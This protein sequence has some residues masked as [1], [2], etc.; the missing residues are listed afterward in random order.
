MSGSLLFD[1]MSHW[2]PRN[3]EVEWV[4]IRLNTKKGTSNVHDPTLDIQTVLNRNR[5]LQNPNIISNFS[6]KSIYAFHETTRPNQSNRNSA[7]FKLQIDKNSRP[8]VNSKSVRENNYQSQTS[9][10]LSLA[11]VS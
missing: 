7:T 5:I 1:I 10:G 2:A 8:L 9:R 4:I 3:T 6:V 11:Q